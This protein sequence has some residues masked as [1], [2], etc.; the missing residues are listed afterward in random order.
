[1]FLV[2]SCSLWLKLLSVVLKNSKQ[3][4]YEDGGKQGIAVVS[5]RATRRERCSVT[6][7]VFLRIVMLV[8]Y[9]GH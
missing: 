7:L 9:K 3:V 6:L 1:M 4:N 5:G 8:F 2:S